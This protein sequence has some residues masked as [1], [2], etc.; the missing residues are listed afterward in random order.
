MQGTEKNKEF[1]TDKSRH[2]IVFLVWDRVSMRAEGISKHIGARLYL[3][4][5][6]RIRHP[7]LFIRTLQILWKERPGIIICQ[8]P[9]ITCALIAMI[10]KYF[11]AWTSRPK[12]LID[13]HTGA[14]TRPWSKKVSRLI[15]KQASATI[16]INKE[17]QNL[18]IQNYK[19][20]PII[21]E[22]PIP[23]FTDILSSANKQDGYKIEQN[24][25]C[26][27]VVISSF[28]YDEPLQAVF[29]A[30]SDLP[31]VYFYVTGDKKNADKKL[32]LKKPDNVTMTDF[33]DYETY[34]KLLQKV[35]V[36]MDLTTDQKSI[37]A[38][39]YEAVALEQPLITSNW[40]P[41]RRYFNKGAIFINNSSDDIKKAVMTA[42]TK[43]EELSK[44][45]HD[46]KIEKMEEWR[47]KTSNFDCLFR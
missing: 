47:K 10:F 14:I 25:T 22:D 11:F 21:L 9:P 38:G 42:M 31:D 37:V 7:A 24:A 29:D 39:A 36:I 40:V 28:A 2:K 43:R 33:L 8:S 32:L 27:I 19:L 15:M 4:F 6:T 30:A 12:I 1:V 45:M 35:D 26:N 3:L 17:Q 44:E 23:D 41:V 46:L 16:V 34:I 5:T 13:V 20:K 18:L